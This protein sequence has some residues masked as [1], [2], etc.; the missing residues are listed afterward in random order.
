MKT[1]IISA[2]NFSAIRVEGIEEW[3]KTLISVQEVNEKN[4]YDA[5]RMVDPKTGSL[6]AITKLKAPSND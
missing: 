6:F 3:I 4:E 1:L 5:I 2:D